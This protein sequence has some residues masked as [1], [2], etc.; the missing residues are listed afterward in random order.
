LSVAFVAR[1]V[2]PYDARGLP[3]EGAPAASDQ[4]Q[5]ALVRA[6]LAALA[7]E[8]VGLRHADV[9]RRPFVWRALE[10]ATDVDAV[11]LR[12]LRGEE[13]RAPSPTRA[14]G[15]PIRLDYAIEAEVRLDPTL[16]PDALVLPRAALATM[17]V[18][19]VAGLLVDEGRAR[20]L[21]EAEPL[22]TS[23]SAAHVVDPRLDA[24]LE[25]RPLVVTLGARVAAAQASRGTHAALGLALA[26]RLGAHDGDRVVVH[27]PL[28]ASAVDEASTLLT[29]ARP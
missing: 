11:R 28:G 22:V 27:L 23:P 7:D 4:T 5:A 20:D 13:A 17:L 19:I 3:A 12:P 24:A 15:E 2:G 14:P 9:V 6:G 1:A 21:G 29:D 16:P 18:P 10:S 25:E 26:A 8:L